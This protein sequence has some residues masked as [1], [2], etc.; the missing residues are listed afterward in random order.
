MELIVCQHLLA[1]SHKYML[2][3]QFTTNPLEKEFSRICQGSAPILTVSWETWVQVESYQ[4]LKKKKG[5]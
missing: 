3:G 1:T 5:T 2:L 4:R